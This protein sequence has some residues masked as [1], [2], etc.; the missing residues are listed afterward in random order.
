[1]IQKK[2]FEDRLQEIGQLLQDANVI[3]DPQKLT[4]LS[5]EHKELQDALSLFELSENLNKQIISTK[6]MLSL[7]PDPEVKVLAEEELENLK[8]RLQETNTKLQAKLVPGDPNDSQDTVF[9]IR[10]GAGGDEAELFAAELF[11][12]YSR[13]ADSQ[14]LGIEIDN[15][16]ITP[17]GGIKELI[18]EIHGFNTYKYFKYESGVH[19]VQRVPETEKQGRVHTSTVTVAVL[20]LPKESTIEIKPEDL[21]ID[22]FKSTGHGGQ[23]VN[24]TDSAVRITHIPTGVVVS[25]Q[26]E[27]SQI[28]NKDKAMRVLSARLQA[29]KDERL[30][31]ERGQERKIQIGTGDR[32]E[33]IRTYNFPQDRVTDHRIQQSFHNIESIM[34]GNLEPIF[35]ALQ[36]AEQ[37]ARLASRNSKS[38]I[39]NSK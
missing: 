4:N 5:Q 10:A 39:L 2:G 31:N 34:E 18:A 6:E 21:R 9:E 37:N 32:S 29:A 20:P 16:N 7:E 22:V 19:R 1:M 30:A 14:K 13:F 35:E 25:C 24:T 11:R 38:E 27:K 3:S 17:L 36:Q 12:A 26:D 33:K 8:K 23:S 15:S 28:K